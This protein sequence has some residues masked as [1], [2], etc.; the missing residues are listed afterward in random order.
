MSLLLVALLLEIPEARAIYDEALVHWKTRTEEGLSTSLDLFTRAARIDP[1]FAR[2]RAGIASASCLLAL[3][4]YRAPTEVMPKAHG[5][6][7]EAIRLDDSLAEAHASLGL[8]RYL[9]DWNFTDAEKSFERALMLDPGYSSAHHW[10]AMMLMA[11]KR[12]EES[13]REIDRAF[14]L[15]PES[16][17]YSTKRGTILMAAGRLDEAEAHLRRLDSGLAR[18]ELGFLALERGN[19]EKAKAGLDPDD[20][21][22][23]LVL[24][25][26]GER[27]KTRE[28]LDALKREESTS[29]VSPIAFALL[30]LG[31]GEKEKALDELERAYEMR[32]SALVYLRSEPGLSSLR[33][34]PRFRLLLE[35]MGL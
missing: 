2:A 35:K 14:A 4:G 19:L 28:M 34:E 8:V 1:E 27:D 13:L 17:L 15:D 24:G 25:L 21:S 29:Y 3:Y 30:Y 22:Y 10:Y 6:A 11:T 7:L 26:L 12:F 18:R 23:G 20:A 9:Y 33:S 16:P 31:L 5:A 32:D